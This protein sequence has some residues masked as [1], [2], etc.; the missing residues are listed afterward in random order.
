MNDK[1]TSEQAA[2][3]LGLKASTLAVWRSNG[4]YQIPFIKIGSKVLYLQRD[5]DHWIAS[6]RQLST[7]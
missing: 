7:K 2:Q 6:R 3:Y 5:L 1:L 4:R